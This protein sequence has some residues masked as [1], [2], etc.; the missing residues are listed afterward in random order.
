M[1]LLISE[2][3]STPFTVIIATHSTAIVASLSEFDGVRIA[4]MQMGALRPY[5]FSQ[6]PRPSKQCFRS[7]GL[8]LY[9]TCS[10]LSLFY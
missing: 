6:F 10:M 9:R 3:T 1:S 4:F 7:S 2:V 5:N 8:T